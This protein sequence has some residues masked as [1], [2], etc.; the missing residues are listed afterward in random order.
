[1]VDGSR[2]RPAECIEL[3]FSL[4]PRMRRRYSY[5]VPGDTRGREH[6]RDVGKHQDGR[7]RDDDDAPY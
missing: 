6:E 2:A 4:T 7:P 1:M 3:S 5:A